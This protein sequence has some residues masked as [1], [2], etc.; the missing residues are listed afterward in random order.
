MN[1]YA[2]YVRNENKSSKSEFKGLRSGH[3]LRDSDGY[4]RSPVLKVR[5]KEK[6]G[7]REGTWNFENSQD[8]I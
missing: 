5:E 8:E 6:S 7:M 1:V 3:E 2:T 4:I